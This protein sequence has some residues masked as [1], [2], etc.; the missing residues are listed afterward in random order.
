MYNK[1]YIPSFIEIV[2]LVLWKKIYKEFL[3]YIGM[4]ASLVMWPDLHE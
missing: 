4:A 1:A 2:P 3:P